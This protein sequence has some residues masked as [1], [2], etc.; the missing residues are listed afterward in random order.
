ML[1]EA[2]VRQSVSRTDDKDDDKGG[3]GGYRSRSSRHGLGLIAGP[4]GETV[5]ADQIL[6]KSGAPDAKRDPVARAHNAAVREAPD[7]CLTCMQRRDG[8]GIGADRC[9][10]E[11]LDGSVTCGVGADV[12]R[13]MR[14]HDE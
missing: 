5:I 2:K 1:L 14:V 13:E 9:V 4:F 10:Y 3:R 7:R 8:Y 11:R 12:G 6:H